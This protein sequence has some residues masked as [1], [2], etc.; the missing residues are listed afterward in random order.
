[1]NLNDLLARPDSQID[2]AAVALHL[3]ADEYPG[4]D[5]A[6]YMQRLGAHAAAVR[7]LIDDAMQDSS[8]PEGPP[9]VVLEALARHLFQRQ[10]FS[11]N[12]AE[13]YDPRNSFLNEVLDRRIGIPITLS[14][15]YL[16]VGQRLG[17][18]ISPISF[19]THFLLRVDIGQM[20]IVV[21]PFNRG[22]VLDNDKLIA[23]LIAFLGDRERAEAYLP[24][25]LA[26]VPRRE[27]VARMLR[28]LKAIY[29]SR[30]DWTRALR[31]TDQLLCVEP[32]QAG[33]IRDRG[34][35]YVALECAQ[36]AFDDFERY[37]S[38]RP[39]ADDAAQIES[40]MVA[41]RKQVARL[42]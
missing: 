30:K 25:A 16:E 13:Y 6:H 2:L 34:H 41:L 18:S 33:E 26:S 4:L 7:E 28:N 17:L 20:D 11:G 3:A 40:R 39:D 37:L 8:P 1:M 38:L 21:D 35:I 14:I 5:A 22:A 29:V 24:K 12:A 19:P 36:A 31:V 32:E 23:H 9:G 10:G 42:N 27:V 15:V